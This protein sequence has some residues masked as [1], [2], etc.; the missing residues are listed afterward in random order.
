MYRQIYIHAVIGYLET[1]SLLGLV[2]E[3]QG[4]IIKIADEIYEEANSGQ[5]AEVLKNYRI[6]TINGGISRYQD[7]CFLIQ[8]AKGGLSIQKVTANPE[9]TEN[10][11]NYSLA[12][13]SCL[14]YL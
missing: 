7:I 14:W 6:Y 1:G 4:K 12:C 13:K 9:V 11:K 2:G 10:N 5:S 3:E 8:N